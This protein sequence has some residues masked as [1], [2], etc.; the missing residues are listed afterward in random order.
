MILEFD[1]FESLFR[2]DGLLVRSHSIVTYTRIG[3]EAGARWSPISCPL[4]SVSTVEMKVFHILYVGYFLD[5]TIPQKRPIRKPPTGNSG[6][7]T[8]VHMDAHLTFG[9]DVE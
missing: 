5:G 7:I 2:N 1:D 8:P 9:A 4:S 6:W 3:W